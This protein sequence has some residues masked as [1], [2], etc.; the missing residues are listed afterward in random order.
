[1]KPALNLFAFFALIAAAFSASGAD[2]S[3][4]YLRDHDR[5]VFYGDSITDQRL[6]TTFVESYVVT[7]FPKLDLRFIHSGW[8]GDRVTGGGGGPIDT[9][10]ERDVV[11]Y[12]PT[13][14][15]IMLGMNDASYR[16]FDEAIF[17]TYS[18]GYQYIIEQVKKRAPT[19]RIT[20]IQPSPF[21]DVTQPPKFEGG[22]NAV[23]LRYSAF[24]K[25][26]GEREQLTIA[27]LNGPVVAA[28][29]KAKALDPELAK[30]IIPDRVHPGAAGH[31]L[32]A[33]ALLKA[34]NAPAVVSSVEIDAGSKR[35]ET[36]SAK[37]T[38]LQTG[39]R[40]SWTE[41][42]EAL[43]MPL[44]MGEPVLMLALNSSDFIE[45]LDRQILTVRGLNADRYGLT[46]DGMNAGE[47][48]KEDLG[49]GI[50]LATN[51]TPMLKQA[52]E[53]HKK[54][55]EHNN[56]HFARWRQVQVPMA[57]YKSAR[58][59]KAV[60]DLIAALDEDEGALVQQQRD[61][62]RPREHRFELTPR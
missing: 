42:D 54:T 5:V 57:Q 60:A 34:W 1:M 23:L 37:V 56:L 38:D 24:V 12:H 59:Q 14:L 30:K 28:L 31:L 16:A 43:P 53:V 10:L 47:F 49:R 55:I 20:V 21:D 41:L 52:V 44:E 7:R 19:A 46:I 27:D 36:K 39:G 22:Y 45:A 61:L 6:Y 58:A 29:E 15:T 33:E 40:I 17:S 3:Q 2:R 50:N 25:E 62:A 8:G 48:S 4:F 32:M 13:V 9:R 26:L 18:K 35:A 51:S 11:A